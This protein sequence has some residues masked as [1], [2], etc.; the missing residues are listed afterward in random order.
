MESFGSL[1]SEDSEQYFKDNAKFLKPTYNVIGIIG[2][3]SSGK[4][5]LLNALFG[6][7][8][9]VMHDEVERKQTTR[10]IWCQVVPE[11]RL[12]VLDIEGTD[13]R[14]RWEEKQTY[15]RRTA[16]FGLA[17]S[18]V[19][20]VNLWL[21][22]IGRFGAS[23]YD[24]IRTIFELNM[25]LFDFESPKKLVFVVRDWMVRENESKIKSMLVGDMRRL[26][27]SI[28]KTDAQSKIQFENV[29]HFEFVK[30]RSLKYEE[31]GFKEDVGRF[32][33]QLMD[34]ANDSNFLKDQN[35]KNVPITDF[36]RYMSQSWQSISQNKDL[37][38]P[39]QK[40]MISNY[41][42]SEIKDESLAD[43][44][45]ALATLAQTADQKPDFDISDEIKQL[46]N[47]SLEYFVNN[48]Q[49]YDDKV[50]QNMKA[51]LTK[52]LEADALS[53]FKPQ[54]DRWV[55]TTLEQVER[56]LKK[57]SSQSTSDVSK[58]LKSIVTEKEA[59]RT[60]YRS[61]IGKYAI[62]ALK[63][64]EFY[65]YFEIELNGIISKFL[66]SS[67]QAF[68]KKMI[69][70]YVTDI[71]SRISLT[72]MNFTQE[73]WDKFNQ[74]CED[75]L[76]RF[77]DEIESLKSNFSEVKVLFTD[78][79]VNEF[80]EDL[81]A[82]IKSLLRSKQTYILEYLLENFKT[83]FET[84][85]NGQTH[86]WRHLSDTD[87]TE[88][89]K[90]AKS[91]F[92][93]VVKTLEKPVLL[94]FDNEI[95]LPIDETAKLRKRF[96]FETNKVLEEAFNKKYDKN[97][98]QK[99]PRWMWLILAYFMHD[100]ILE[101]MKNPI[102]FMFVIMVASA[103]GYLYFTNKI[104]YVRNYYGMVKGLAVNKIIEATFKT[105]TTGDR[106]TGLSSETKGQ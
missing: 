85:P 54:N 23:N 37:N 6:V 36:F 90:K 43:F 99:I 61:F 63:A 70:G 30:L 3:Q 74:F 65:N 13:S 92:S 79:V 77:T 64:N 47:S 81:I 83:K 55:R 102:W 87:I 18:N 1:M 68:C 84:S 46:M 91:A 50:S 25:Q 22:D 29:F 44:R 17:I 103:T 67:T 19:L 8:F 86:M 20:L 60:K 57:L 10:G 31:E 41:R 11:K 16:L 53:A 49:S 48:T 71:D 9:D 88:L 26:W 75:T 14:E 82:T 101:W 76:Q 4:S 73:N 52:A 93:D 12:L 105:Q 35:F 95:I 59:S 27:D 89:F 98:F 38:I 45:T 34:P 51:N 39:N 62:D 33:A 66:T 32:R 28:K 7:D 104:D 58:I 78:E 94:N 15:E 72:Y 56:T 21:N 2:A 5:T 40:I 96:E 69:R 42:C 97:A 24:I 100:N 80:R 106:Q